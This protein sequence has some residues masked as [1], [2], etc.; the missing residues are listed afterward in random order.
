MKWGE[1]RREHMNSGFLNRPEQ[2][3][4][5]FSPRKLYSPL[6]PLATSE[7][8]PNILHYLTGCWFDH[9]QD[10][11]WSVSTPLFFPQSPCASPKT[12]HILT[13]K[14]IFSIGA[15]ELS[16]DILHYLTG[17]RFDHG[18]DRGVVGIS[19]F[20]SEPLPFSQAYVLTAESIFYW[21]HCE[22]VNY[23]PTSYI[24][25]LVVDSTTGVRPR[26]WRGGYPP[27][28]FS[29]RALPFPHCFKI[30]LW[31]L[32]KKEGQKAQVLNTRES[33]C[34]LQVWSAPTLQVETTYVCKHF[35]PV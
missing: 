33:N 9:G 4:A 22:Q 1:Y 14:T 8:S 31:S 26:P 28:Y 23:R 13:T 15:S 6:G 3:L 35:I 19:I 16:T 29:L 30:F 24:I 27:L 5:T 11:A 12:G 17:C 34:F 18:Q 7:L 10:R 20:P 21:N 2:A 25:W 32:A